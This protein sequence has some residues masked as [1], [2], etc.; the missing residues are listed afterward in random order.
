MPSRIA[1]FS[2]RAASLSATD[3][4]YFAIAVKELLIARTRYGTQPVGKILRQLQHERSQSDDS[5]RGDVDLARISWAIGAAAA[6]VPW[7]SDCLPQ[8]MAADRWLRRYGLQPRLFVGI[9]K[10]A[11]GQL[12]AHAWLVC[13]EMTVTGGSGR[14][15]ATLIEPVS[16]VP[17]EQSTSR[18][19]S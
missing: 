8:S 10:A 16:P 1:L 12:E 3:W 19:I 4:L 2:K 13:R 15:F 9:A 5:A 7:R 18:F 14:E 6:R 11:D 17:R